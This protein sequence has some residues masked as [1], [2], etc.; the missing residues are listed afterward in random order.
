MGNRRRLLQLRLLPEPL[1]DEASLAHGE[2]RLLPWSWP[3]TRRS[4]VVGL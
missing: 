1:C 3:A 2:V 4:T